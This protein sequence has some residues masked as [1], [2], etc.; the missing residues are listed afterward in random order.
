MIRHLLVAAAAAGALAVSCGSGEPSGR[1]GSAEEAVERYVSAAG[2]RERLESLSSIHTRDSIRMAGLAGTVESWY[3]RRPFRGRTV[4]EIGPVRQEVLMLGDSVWS[5]DRNG[6]VTPGDPQA[7]TEAE[8]ARL[9]MFHS[10]YLEPEGRISL[11]GD[12]VIEGDSA[13]G[14]QVDAQQ[15]FRLYLS[16]ESWLP[17]MQSTEVMGMRALSYPGDYREVDGVMVPGSTRDT[18]PALGQGIRTRSILAELDEPVPDTVFALAGG[19][20]DW[21]LESPGERFPFTLSGE[22]IYIDGTVTGREATY[23][24]DS[25]AGATVI[26]SALAAQLGLDAV[27][28]F[29]A[30]GVG[31]TSSFAFVEVPEYRL[32]P[33]VISGQ[34]LAVMP[35][36][37]RFYPSTGMHI[38]M[39]IGYD[40]LSRFVT[41]IDYGAGEMA[42]YESEG[43]DYDGDGRELPVEQS[44]SLLSFRATLEDSIELR[45][46]LDTGAGGNLHLT[47]SFFESNPGFLE[48][49]QVVESTVEGVGGEDTALVFRAGTLELADYRVP[50]GM[51]S[52]FSGTAALE[53]YDGIAGNGIL[54]R[55]VIWLDYDRSRVILEPS[56]LFDEGL[57]ADHTGFGVRI[58][59][60]E[61]VVKQ[62]LEGS[63]ADMAGLREGDVLVSLEGTPV[64]P[65]S[66]DRLKSLL[67]HSPGRRLEAVVR[68]EGEEMEMELTSA[69]L[70]PL[71]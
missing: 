8:M 22:H 62:V 23:L 15:P 61:L 64:G 26:D 34:K 16:R 25:G 53:E 56:S 66:L 71:D 1:V 37:A 39:V 33:A 67:P 48:D 24:L 58:R 4:V 10:V 12:T 70:L 18:L 49:R 32:G 29:A 43:F 60:G 46:L 14:L 47:P 30:Q 52:R 54:S 2:G 57:P 36:D 21:E 42:L 5:L 69:E 20:A 3:T 31:G 40:L 28:E 41:M 68:R 45:L 38:G 63:P 27:G 9:T 51:C 55:F 11:L 13:V 44:M 17:V 6:R 59:G 35:L 65:E 7:R 19:D 50:A